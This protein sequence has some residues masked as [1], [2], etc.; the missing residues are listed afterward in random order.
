MELGLFIPYRARRGF[1]GVPRAASAWRRVASLRPRGK[2]EGNL[3]SAHLGE[4][5]LLHRRQV[6][7]L[8]LHRRVLLLH[9][10]HRVS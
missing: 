8:L 4:R 9:R 1:G 5:P 3:P 7:K 6:L 2:G 10:R